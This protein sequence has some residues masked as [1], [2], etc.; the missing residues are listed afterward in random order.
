MEIQQ[1]IPILWGIILFLFL[2]IIYLLVSL[3]NIKSRQQSMMRGQNGVSLEEII[4]K[5]VNDIKDIKQN[6]ATIEKDI[7]DINAKLKKAFTKYGAMKFSA[8]D[9]VGGDQSFALAVLDDENNGVI[10][11]SLK[12]REGSNVYL[13]TVENGNADIS[14]MSEEI[15]VLKEAKKGR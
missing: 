4:I 11:S 13:K 1:S 7:V 9:D 12:G 2:I 8:F 3:K 6:I 10:I 15:T 14:L 5:N